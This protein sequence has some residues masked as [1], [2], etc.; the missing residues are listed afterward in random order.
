[1]SQAP[2]GQPSNGPIAVLHRVGGSVRG[3]IGTLAPAGRPEA[4][5]DRQPALTAFKEFQ[6]SRPGEIDAWLDEFGAGSV[7]VVL[8]A[9][10]VVCRTCTLPAADPEHLAKA[11]A[12]QAEAHQLTAAPSYRRGTAVLPAAA[13]EMSRSGVIVDWPHGAGDKEIPGAADT[14]SKPW[15]SRPVS[16]APDVGCV[17]ALLNGHRPDEPLLWFD[18]ADGSLALAISHAN[19]VILRAARVCAGEADA[20]AGNVSRVVAET[21]LSVGHTPAFTET[22]VNTANQRIGGVDRNAALVVE[23]QTIEGLRERVDGTPEDLLWWRD[24]GVALGALAAASGQLAPLTRLRMNPPIEHPSLARRVLGALSEPAWAARLAV[25]F[26]LVLLLSPLA[27]SGLRL[28]LLKVKLPELE[29]YRAEAKQA[30]AQLAMYRELETGSWPMT[31]LLADVACG[32]PEGID[33]EQ[34]RIGD[35][36]RISGR[37][38]PDKKAN[39]SAPQVVTLMQQNLRDSRIFDEIY[40]NVGDEDAFGAYEFTLDAQVVDAYRRHDYP[41]ELDYGKWTR[42]DRLYGDGPPDL[43]AGGPGAVTVPVGSRDIPPRGTGGHKP[44]ANPEKASRRSDP[45]K[46]APRS[47]PKKTAPADDPKT[48][49]ESGESKKAEEPAN[50]RTKRDPSWRGERGPRRPGRDEPLG[51]SPD[52][53]RQAGPLPASQD[54]PLPLTQQQIDAMS[55]P[56]ALEMWARLSRALQQARLDD[57]TEERLRRDWRLTRGRVRELKSKE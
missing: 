40:P 51:H 30:E 57:E 48:A 55:L 49:A 25:A 34:I 47:D 28:A 36:V 19:G 46:T 45:G 3:L 6:A 18:R 26:V 14:D 9:S 7:L 27:F 32:T 23:P 35:H 33:L 2:S 1:V 56:E 20:W 8:P 11:L 17:A 53:L 50:G 16:F 15:G 54:V 44:P 42:E 37:A 43:E 13:G 38:K 5:A 22:L 41:L 4:P 39:L 12:L 52:D 24:Y 31:K 21:A 29:M 10:A